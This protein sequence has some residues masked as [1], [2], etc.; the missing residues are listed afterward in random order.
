MTVSTLDHVLEGWI[1]PY[2]DKGTSTVQ[3]LLYA[4]EQLLTNN[5][6]LRSWLVF[7]IKAVNADVKRVG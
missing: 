2:V 4:L 1:M 7:A 6:L 3:L 5:L